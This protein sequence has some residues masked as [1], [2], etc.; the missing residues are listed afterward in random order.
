MFLSTLAWFCYIG[1]LLPYSQA[2]RVM[3]IIVPF[4]FLALPLFLLSGA[5]A[6]LAR[7]KE[8]MKREVAE[9]MAHRLPPSS[10]IMAILAGSAFVGLALNAILSWE[11]WLLGDIVFA[12]LALVITV[13]A[14]ALFI[15][16]RS[17]HAVRVDDNVGTT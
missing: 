4:A 7:N 8:A 14:T 10:L 13:S 9:K 11:S 1:A 5:A 12:V 6:L 16:T 3:Y 15:K 2:G 17:L